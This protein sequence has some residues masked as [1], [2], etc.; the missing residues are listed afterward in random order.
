M[1]HI[2]AEELQ[3]FGDVVENGQ[4]IDECDNSCESTQRQYK[5]L[6]VFNN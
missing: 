2:L 1:N 5:C 3:S 6:E 4:Y